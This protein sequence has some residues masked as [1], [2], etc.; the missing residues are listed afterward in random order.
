MISIMPKHGLVYLVMT[1]HYLMLYP[2]RKTGAIDSEKPSTANLVDVYVTLK[3]EPVK[4]GPKKCDRLP[5]KLFVSRQS[6]RDC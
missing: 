3:G 4:K 2:S 1:I 5:A 6:H